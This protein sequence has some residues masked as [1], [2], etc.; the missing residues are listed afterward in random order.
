M[1]TLSAITGFTL[2]GMMLDPGCTAGS[3]NSPRPQR[4]PDPSHRTSFAILVNATA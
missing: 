2:P 3:R 1:S 4:G